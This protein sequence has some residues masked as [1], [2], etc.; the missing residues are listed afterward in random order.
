MVPYNLIVTLLYHLLCAPQ[1]V[2]LFNLHNKPISQ[3]RKVKLRSHSQEGSAKVGILTYRAKAE[4]PASPAISCDA[5]GQSFHL[6]GSIW[7]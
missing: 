6:F 1:T 2:I 7:L 5:L 4:V 3:M